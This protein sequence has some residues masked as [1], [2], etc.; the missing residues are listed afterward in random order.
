MVKET[1]SRKKRW[2]SIIL[3]LQCVSILF[4]LSLVSLWLQVFVSTPSEFSVIPFN[5]AKDTSSGKNY[6]QNR[7]HSTI[8]STE[9]VL[10]PFFFAHRA[11]VG[12]PIFLLN[13]LE[14]CVIPS[15]RLMVY[16]VAKITDKIP[17]P[18]H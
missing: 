12:L 7:S 2:H 5:T 6:R 16:S 13:P 4:W 9:C 18:D 11:A 17:Q 8:L 14:R 1:I 10:I 15:T 3:F